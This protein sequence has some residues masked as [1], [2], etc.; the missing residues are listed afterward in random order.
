MLTVRRV[1]AVLTLTFLITLG[2]LTGDTNVVGVIVVALGILIAL[3]Q[4]SWTAW[5]KWADEYVAWL[6]SG[7]VEQWVA[8]HRAYVSWSEEHRTRMLGAPVPTAA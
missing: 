1:T 5:D 8:W 6:D 3:V 7:D 2:M 4:Y